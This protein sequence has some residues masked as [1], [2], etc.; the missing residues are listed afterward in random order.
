MTA[1]SPGRANPSFQRRVQ[2]DFAHGLML[3]HV[4]VGSRGFAKWHDLVDEDAEL[5]GHPQLKHPPILHA[6]ERGPP[7]DQERVMVPPASLYHPKLGGSRMEGRPLRCLCQ[8]R[9]PPGFDPSRPCGRRPVP[10]P[11]LV[12]DEDNVLAYSAGEETGSAMAQR[13]G[14]ARA[15][16]P[17]LNTDTLCQGGVVIAGDRRVASKP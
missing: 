1:S 15:A 16:N 13:G 3:R 8:G 7:Q 14:A 2:D 5:A 4:A 6:P 9:P 10:G 12:L 17:Q 11:L